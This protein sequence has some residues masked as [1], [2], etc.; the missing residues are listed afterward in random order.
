MPEILTDEEKRKYGGGDAGS[1]SSGDAQQVLT[2][3]TEF[4][5]PRANN[6]LSKHSS[7]G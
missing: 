3:P 6:L 7:S 1:D 5:P 4:A 2:L